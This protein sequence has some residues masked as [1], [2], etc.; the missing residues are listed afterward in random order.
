MTLPSDLEAIYANFGT[1]D[2]R[3]LWIEGTN[4]RFEAYRYFENKP[5]EMIER[6]DTH[7]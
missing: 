7:R 2:K 5:Q 1:D 6:F 3:L 4:V